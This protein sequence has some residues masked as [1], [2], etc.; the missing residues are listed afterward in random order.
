MTNKFA[1]R[2]T[3]RAVIYRD[4]KL[5]I[6]E[7]WHTDKSGTNYHYYSIPG[8]QIESGEDGPTAVAR[9][10]LEEMGVVVKPLWL[11]SDYPQEDG[12]HHHYYWCEYVSGEPQLQNDS[13]EADHDAAI[14]RFE[15][16]WV[17]VRDITP[18]TVHFEYA[19]FVLQLPDVIKNHGHLQPHPS[20]AV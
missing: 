4:D 1:G 14:N 15:P 5:L 7:R 12:C 19:D 20:D 16:R 11:I 6:M 18:K 9:E 2:T 10:I 17:D 8:G 13:E 3:A